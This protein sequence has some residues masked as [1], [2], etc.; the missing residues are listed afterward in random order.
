MIVKHPRMIIQQHGTIKNYRYVGDV[1]LTA[2]ILIPVVR[3][4]IDHTISNKVR[5]RRSDTPLHCGGWRELRNY[6]ALFQM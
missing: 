2:K 6:S 1:S 5:L 3:D 4:I